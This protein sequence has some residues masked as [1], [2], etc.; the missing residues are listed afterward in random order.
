M[1]NV[2]LY[3]LISQER[4]IFNEILQSASQIYILR[5]EIDKH[6]SLKSNGKKRKIIYLFIYLYFCLKWENI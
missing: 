4:F 6:A 3:K 1:N 5:F 2:Y